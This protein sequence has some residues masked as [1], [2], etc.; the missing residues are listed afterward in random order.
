MDH[1]SRED[2]AGADV[3]GNHGDA[4]APAAHPGISVVPCPGHP[5]AVDVVGAS[6]RYDPIHLSAAEWQEF[7]AAV[8]AGRYDDIRA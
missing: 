6:S 5:H 4:D 8:K 7:V 1:T 3:V 2:A